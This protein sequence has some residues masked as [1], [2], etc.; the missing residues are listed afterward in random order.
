MITAR[1]AKERADKRNKEK[2]INQWIQI[3]D[4]ITKAATN[5]SYLTTIQDI[6]E[7]NKL[8]LIELG[9]AVDEVFDVYKISWEK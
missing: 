3:E 9:Y 7:E 8:D 2:S 6:S 4:K 1:E 5:G